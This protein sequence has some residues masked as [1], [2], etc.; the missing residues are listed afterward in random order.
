MAVV[1]RNLSSTDARRDTAGFSITLPRG[2]WQH[3]SHNSPRSDYVSKQDTLR[4]KQE[5]LCG[6]GFLPMTLPLTIHDIW[7]VLASDS[8]ILEKERQ[9][10]PENGHKKLTGHLTGSWTSAMECQNST[11]VIYPGA[12]SMFC[13]L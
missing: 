7:S 8:L 10:T 13:V 5:F 6:S 4:R 1:G 2:S 11:K 9:V 12:Y 3:C